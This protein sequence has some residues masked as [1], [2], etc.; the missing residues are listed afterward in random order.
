MGKKKE[1]KALVKEIAEVLNRN[2]R[3]NYSDTP[4]YI[5]AKVMVDAL[6]SFEKR[7]NER[8]WYYHGDLVGLFNKRGKY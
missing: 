4:D 6:E 5:L 3:E 1:R 8:D 7:S 2:S